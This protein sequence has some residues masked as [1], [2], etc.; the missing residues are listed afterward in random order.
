MKL[1]AFAT[2]VLSSA[3]VAV[4]A[5]CI[6]TANGVTLSVFPLANATDIRPV[7]LISDGADSYTMLTCNENCGAIP[8]DSWYLKDKVLIPSLIQIA[9]YTM[10]DN[11]VP[12]NTSPSFKR[13][14]VGDPVYKYPIYCIDSPLKSAKKGLLSVNGAT[15]KFYLCDNL[16]PT[17]AP[18]ERGDIFYD[19]DPKKSVYPR[20][21][22]RPAGIIATI[23]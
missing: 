5:V 2:F 8:I 13:V 15:N 21:D 16:I 10:T 14:R 1:A 11:P 9:I 6:D 7:K 17:F 23:P 4:K 12:A 20:G 19:V 22:C 3:A 18:T